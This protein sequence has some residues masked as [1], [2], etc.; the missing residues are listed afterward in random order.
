MRDKFT[1]YQGLLAGLFLATTVLLCLGAVN[2]RSPNVHYD[3]KSSRPLSVACSSD[4]FRVYVADNNKV[5]YSDNGGQ[6]WK[7]VLSEKTDGKP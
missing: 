4:G 1:G 3:L 7:I 5:Y 2:F 6:D